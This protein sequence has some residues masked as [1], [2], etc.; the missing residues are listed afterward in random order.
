MQKKGQPIREDGPETHLNK[1]GTPTMGGLMIIFS[2]LISQLLFINIANSYIQITWF[3][4][5]SFA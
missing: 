4:F 5:L 1:A 2:M 3:V